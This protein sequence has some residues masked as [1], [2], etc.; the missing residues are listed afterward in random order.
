MLI[1][2]LFIMAEK[3]VGGPYVRIV[4]SRPLVVW[5]WGIASRVNTNTVSPFN[6][7]EK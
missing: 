3:G 1:P 2:F 6:L 4:V 5:G 7:N